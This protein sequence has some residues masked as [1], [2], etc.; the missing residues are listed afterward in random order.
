[1]AQVL[2]IAQL[3]AGSVHPIVGPLAGVE[4]TFNLH[5]PCMQAAR[6]QD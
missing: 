3:D 6:Q 5:Q 2:R 4:L 1:M